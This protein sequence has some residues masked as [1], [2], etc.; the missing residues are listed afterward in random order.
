MDQIIQE[1]IRRIIDS[2]GPVADALAG[3]TI[4]VTGANGF[5]P[6]YFVDTILLLNK[7]RLRHNPA[8][9]IVLVRRQV[10][11]KDR[12]F[13]AVG[14]P[15]VTFVLHNIVTVMDMPRRPDYIIH[16]ASKAS[17]KEYLAHPLDTVDANVWGTRALLEYAVK[18]PVQGFL[19][20]SSGEI[21]GDPDPRQIPI[22]EN[23]HGNVDPIGPRSMY[24]EAKRF[25]ETLVYLF[26]KEHGVPTKIARPF[27]TYGPRM[28]ITD[29]R[30]I[31]EFM[32]RCF[33]G[34]AI[35][36][37]DSSAVRT[38]AYI[39]DSIEAMWRVL[40]LGKSGEA[41]NVGS[42]EPITIQALAE[43]FADLF[44]GKVRIEQV[45]QDL[46]SKLVATPHQTIPDISKIK[47]ELEFSPKIGFADGVKRLKNWYEQYGNISS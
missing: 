20:V 39:S 11:E 36:V 4:L 14:D 35:Q 45:Q 7:E 41:Y 23:Y 34:E 2:L 32:R 19:F 15:S 18:N 12:M 25:G 13:H 42:D 10:E 8:H 43:I 3:K 22:N 44:S 38:F 6:S 1:D 21:Y 46:L 33:A 9:A 40:L 24:Q 26:W 47:T 17:P 30:V 16:A 31:P 37:T 29:G 28:L 27:H 5:L